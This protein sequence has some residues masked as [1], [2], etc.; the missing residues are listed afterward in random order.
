LYQSLPTFIWVSGTFFT[1][2]QPEKAYPPVLYP[3]FLIPISLFS[4]SLGIC[5]S[6]TPS[7]PGSSS[8]ALFTYSVDGVPYRDR[9]HFVHIGRGTLLHQAV[10]PTARTSAPTRHVVP[11]Y[12]RF[13]RMLSRVW[14]IT[15]PLAA[16]NHCQGV[17]FFPTIHY[18]SLLTC[19]DVIC[20]FTPYTCPVLFRP[21]SYHPCNPATVL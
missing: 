2:L 16:C 13:Y 9:D 17:V 10:P 5:P 7:F 14:H 15:W 11:R 8:L 21:N 18:V 19:I 6:Q 3:Y 12:R 1:P 4:F 20:L